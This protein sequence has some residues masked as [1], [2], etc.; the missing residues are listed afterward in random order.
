M[1]TMQKRC[2]AH[3]NEFVSRRNDAYHAE[4]MR[5]RYNWIFFET[6]KKILCNK[7]S[8]FG[9]FFLLLPFGKTGMGSTPRMVG[10]DDFCQKPP[11]QMHINLG[12]SYRLVP[13]HELNRAQIG[14]IF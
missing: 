7:T 9:S 13:Q 6:L 12:S 8:Q 14:T 2:G 10:I 11:V 3:R 4:I 1:R 5:S